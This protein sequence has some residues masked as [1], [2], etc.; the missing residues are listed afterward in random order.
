MPARGL[1]SR[2]MILPWSR[3][4]AWPGDGPGGAG[5]AARAD[6][7]ARPPGRGSAWRRRDEPWPARI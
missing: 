3:T 2:S 1:A 5:W 7:G 6:S 4:P